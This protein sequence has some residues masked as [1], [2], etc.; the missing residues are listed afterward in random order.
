MASQGNTMT[1]AHLRAGMPKGDAKTQAHSDGETYA[2]ITLDLPGIKVHVFPDSWDQ[3][4]EL[5]DLLGSIADDLQDRVNDEQLRK[6]E[7][8][9]AMAVELADKL[10]RRNG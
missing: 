10:E 3:A 8:R 6:N 7:D 2:V 5:A 1:M 4:Q 9:E